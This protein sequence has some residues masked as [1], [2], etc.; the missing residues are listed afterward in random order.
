MIKVTT[1]TIQLTEKQEEKIWF[2]VRDLFEFQQNEECTH[3]SFLGTRLNLKTLNQECVFE[4][5]TKE[6]DFVGFVDLNSRK[7]VLKRTLKINII[8]IP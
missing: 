4:L 6:N 2:T 1:N 8:F 5:G 3:C 7:Q